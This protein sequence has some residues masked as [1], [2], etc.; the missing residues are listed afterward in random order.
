MSF[1]VLGQGQES[2]NSRQ[3]HGG[4]YKGGM[5]GGQ[6]QGDNLLFLWFPQKKV[7]PVTLSTYGHHFWTCI[8]EEACNETHLYTPITSPFL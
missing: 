5:W 1:T 4:Q 8:R 3:G 2:R 7:E 6:K